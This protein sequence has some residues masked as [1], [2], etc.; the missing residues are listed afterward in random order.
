[1]EAKLKYPFR[2]PE[3][4]ELTY[5]Q[6]T[7]FIISS[8]FCWILHATASQIHESLASHLYAESSHSEQHVAELMDQAQVPETISNQVQ[9]ITYLFRYYVLLY[10]WRH[11]L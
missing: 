4:F 10:Q 7:A 6:N 9:F 8:C 11:D 3:S 2:P 5:I 1:M